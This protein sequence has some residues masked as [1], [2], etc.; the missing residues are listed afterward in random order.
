MHHVHGTEEFAAV[1]DHLLRW[2]APAFGRPH[3]LS[4]PEVSADG[5]RVLVT[6]SVLER[7]EGVPVPRLF[8]V[9][10]GA[11]VPAAS[12]DGASLGGRFAPDGTR[13]AYLRAPHGEE[14]FQLCLRS[15]AEPEAVAA[16]R[17]KGTVEY[18]RWSPA[19]DRVLIGVAGNGADLPGGQGSGT[20]ARTDPELPVWHPT[21]ES[22]VPEF[23]WR[24]LWIY[25]VTTGALAPASPEGVNCWEASW[26]GPD[27]LLAITS[28][29]PSE[30][31]WYDSTLAIIDPSDRSHCEVLVS[32]VQLAL[33]A[34]S[35][36]GRYASV[37]EG[38]C[39]DRQVMAGDLIVIDL[40]SD[41][42]ST[43]DTAGTD[44]TAAEW[45]APHRLGY[46]G[47][48]GLDSVLARYDAKTGAVV[49]LRSTARSSGYRYPDAAFTSSGEALV[50]ED[51][52]R[53][54]HQLVRVSAASAE[55]LASVQHAGTDYLL[56]V[57]GSSAAV[58]WAAPDGL[59]IEG[60]LAVPEGDGPFPLVVNI[61]GGPVWAFQDA[62]SMRYPWVPLLVSRGYA[63]LSPNPRGSGGRGQ[64][65]A[66]RV[67]GDMGGRDTTDILSGI[68]DLVGRGLVDPARVG[69][70]G[71]SY[72]GFMSSW[73]VTQDQRFAAAVP[74]SP[75]TNWYSQSFTS[76][77][78]GWGKAFLKS[79][80][81]MP[82]TMAHTRS[83]VLRASRVRTPCL[84]VA[85]ALD[86]C[87]PA[88]QARE[89]HQALTAHGVESSLVIYPEE[90]HGIRSYS[91]MADFL[92][93]VT[94]WFDRHM[95]A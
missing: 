19:G 43:V 9:E 11:L 6:G 13:F 55:V 73:L 23:A 58:S 18:L 91:A 95:P 34:A 82:G 60:V 67:V 90:G 42:R 5:S 29:S 69:L 36:D 10:E 25:D 83:P 74:V 54:P 93:R 37:V 76:N 79:D 80:P 88:A 32:Q 12:S 62:W 68:D 94:L 49:E 28:G 61:H 72:G 57:C 47:Q 77:V 71:G 17:V 50:V 81:E 1:E 56:S 84:N 2:H 38:V 75:V 85:G 40:A 41:A 30:D 16:P 78:A 22:G 92:T 8:T 52:Y 24:T 39:S 44:V 63:V 31:S 3:A 14:G 21:V 89:F 64:D 45:F 7:L 15:L 70:I 87:T 51:A 65:F 35:A 27:R 86:R 46:A 66:G 4:E 20:T 59:R 53:L 26:C 33:P 48:R